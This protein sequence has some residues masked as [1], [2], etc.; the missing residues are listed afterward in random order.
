MRERYGR[1]VCYRDTTANPETVM[2]EWMLSARCST[3]TSCMIRGGHESGIEK[4][5][6]DED[7]EEDDTT[8]CMRMN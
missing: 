2:R 3:V 4:V 8:S 5:G 7:A 1:V 6:R